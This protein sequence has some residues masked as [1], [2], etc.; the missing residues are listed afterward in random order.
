MIT[1]NVN[2]SNDNSIPI[3]IQDYLRN[4]RHIDNSND[5]GIL[6]D[7]MCVYFNNVSD[8]IPE[9]DL[10]V[11]MY[12]R[13]YLSKVYDKNLL[14]EIDKNEDL[15]EPQK[16]E[17]KKRLRQELEHKIEKYGFKPS[18]MEDMMRAKQIIEK[19][20]VFRAEHFGVFTETK[21]D[22]SRGIKQFS[23]I[24]ES[25]CSLESLIRSKEKIVSTEK[26]KAGIFSR[27]SALHKNNVK[28]WEEDR[29]NLFSSY[30]RNLS[31]VINLLGI[32]HLRISYSTPD[33]QEYTEDEIKDN[34]YKHK[35][36]KTKE[37]RFNE[38]A[39]DLFFTELMGILKDM[40]EAYRLVKVHMTEILDIGFNADVNALQRLNE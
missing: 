4:G 24:E 36:I 2:N 1:A 32:N 7:S 39:D 38:E 30:E 31:N 27:L 13:K 8:K 16:V 34:L 6:L 19:S 35:I 33:N 37:P 18:F 40:Q 3:D 11:E 15:S 26:P 28:V 17:V 29:E 25:V 10:T 9:V 20:T 22:I 23:V 21:D 12:Y 14:E 5:I